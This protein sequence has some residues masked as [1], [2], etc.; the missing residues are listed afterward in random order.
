MFGNAAKEGPEEGTRFTD[1]CPPEMPRVSSSPT[2][3]S[4]MST[5]SSSLMTLATLAILV[6]RGMSAGR[7]S[8]AWYLPR[9]RG[10]QGRAVSVSVW[11]SAW[12]W[13]E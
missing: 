12:A 1:R 8:C 6:V 10:V 4:M 3:D 9:R 2:T 5:R 7:R 11:A 13:R